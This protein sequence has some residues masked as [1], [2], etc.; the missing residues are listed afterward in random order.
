MII[1]IIIGVVAVII[2]ISV[3]VCCARKKSRSQDRG[4]A[5]NHDHC[6]NREMVQIV[7]VVTPFQPGVNMP[8]A[9]V[10]HLQGHHPAYVL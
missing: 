8:A 6:S 2:L 5:D 4:H 1:F 9:P 3:C 7:P 10:M